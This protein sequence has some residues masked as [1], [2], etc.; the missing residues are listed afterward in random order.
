MQ[1]SDGEVLKLSNSLYYTMTLADLGS[2]GLTLEMLFTRDNGG[3]KFD[4]DHYQALKKL[5]IED[6]FTV[7]QAL[8]EIAGLDFIQAQ[9]VSKGLRREEVIKLSN[10]FHIFTLIELFFGYGANAPSFGLAFV[11]NFCVCQSTR[12]LFLPIPL[13]RY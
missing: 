8:A 7:E 10:D 1:R 3:H 5:I 12:S 9:G 11:T 2:Y 4:Y 6:N 13:S